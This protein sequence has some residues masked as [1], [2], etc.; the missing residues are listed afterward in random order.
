MATKPTSSAS[1]RS[2]SPWQ[3]CA[4]RS[5]SRQPHW[6][7]RSRTSTCRKRMSLPLQRHRRCRAL[8]CRRAPRRS[9]VFT[10]TKRRCR[11]TG[12]STSRANCCSM[13]AAKVNSNCAR[14]ETM[15]IGS[16]RRRADMCSPS[17]PGATVRSQS[18]W[19]SKGLLC[20]N[21]FGSRPRSRISRRCVHWREGITVRSWT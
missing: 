14:L 3:S 8:A 1:R 2:N 11:E 21:L 18:V 10:G 12:S 20:A 7:S 9:R 16:S 17:L 13:A 4:M 5:T 15:R 6:P 19:T